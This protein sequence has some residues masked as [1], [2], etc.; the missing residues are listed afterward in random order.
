LGL[1]RSGFHA[2][3]E[4]ATGDGNLLALVPL[5]IVRWMGHSSETMTKLYS[6]EIPIEDVASAFSKTFGNQIGV[7]ETVETEVAA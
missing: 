6:G 3:V 2:S 7:L 4:D 1:P 5:S